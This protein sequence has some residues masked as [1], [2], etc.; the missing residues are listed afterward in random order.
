VVRL[1][2]QERAMIR[3][4]GENYRIT[5]QDKVR[6]AGKDRVKLRGQEKVS[7]K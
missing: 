1:R 3:R 5:G 4:Q 7:L 2:G 6:H